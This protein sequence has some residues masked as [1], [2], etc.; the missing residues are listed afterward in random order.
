[1]GFYGSN[2]FVSFFDGKVLSVEKFKVGRPNKYALTDYDYLILA[3]SGRKV[4][5]IL[6]VEP[7]LEPGEEFRQ[8]DTL[9]E[10]ILSPYTGGDFRHAHLEGIKLSFPKITS[11][12]EEGIGEVIHVTEGYVDIQLR[13]FSQAGDLN[14]LGCCGG[15]LNGSIPYAGY[16]GII[17]IN[18]SR[19]ITLLGRNYRATS[20][21][22][23][24]TLFEVKRGLLRNWEYGPV[25]KVL[26]NEPIDGYPLIESILSYK[27]KP[28]VR[29]FKKLSLDEGDEVDVWSLTGNNMG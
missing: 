1:M 8:G 10:T 24:V 12:R 26:R 25:F 16:G 20:S 14:G 11:V 19:N 9:G 4:I 18:L 5:K 13:T 2:E 6:H 22:K 23:N 17:G 7:Y 27:G 3:E 21:R 29:I 28:F 15:L